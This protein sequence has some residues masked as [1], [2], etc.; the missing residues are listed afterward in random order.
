MTINEAIAFS[1]QLKGRLMQLTSLRDKVSTTETYWTGDTSK[2]VTE[3]NYDVKKVDQRITLIQNWLY[4]I[5]ARI[6]EVNA[7]TSIDLEVPV[8]GLLAP[9]E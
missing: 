3:A 4:R 2:K 1:S 9:L 7:K 5:D 8:E 6:K